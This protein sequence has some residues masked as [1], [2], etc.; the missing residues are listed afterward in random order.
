MENCLELQYMHYFWSCLITLFHFIFGVAWS[1]HKRLPHFFVCCIFS[2]LSS[3]KNKS[4][5]FIKITAPSTII[6]TPGEVY[7]KVK[8]PSHFSTWERRENTVRV[9]NAFK[10]VSSLLYI[11][12]L[13]LKKWCMLEN[14]PL[15]DTSRKRSIMGSPSLQRWRQLLVEL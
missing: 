14:G 11:R 2:M 5:R 7:C 15:L 8:W 6:G 12:E 13:V 9:L 3:R 10:K 4:N 1:L